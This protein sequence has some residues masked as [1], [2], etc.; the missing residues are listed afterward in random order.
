ME[1]TAFKAARITQVDV[2]AKPREVT[3]VGPEKHVRAT[4]RATGITERARGREIG[5]LRK[6]YWR[7]IVSIGTRE[8]RVWLKD[9]GTRWRETLPIATFRV[10]RRE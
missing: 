4:P 8:R 1:A 6:M 5:D 7:Y 10:K 2:T 9:I 3:A